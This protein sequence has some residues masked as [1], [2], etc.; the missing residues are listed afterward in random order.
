MNDLAIS[1]F[2]IFVVVLI[3]LGI[4]WFTN[5]KQKDKMRKIAE[6][7]AQKGWAY[8][9][10]REPLTW[11]FR[12]Q[13]S[14]WSIE[15]L[16]RSNSIESGP[17]SSN[18][19][20]STIFF[21]MCPGSA[22]I[23]GPRTSHIDLGLIGDTL[24]QQILKIALGPD[25]QNLTEIQAGSGPFRQKFMVWAI[26]PTDVVNC[27]IPAIEYSLIT[28]KGSPLLIKRSSQGLFIECREKSIDSIDEIA[29]L[30]NIGERVISVLR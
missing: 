28:W 30:I 24:T 3:C 19:A 2:L 13:S 9:N 14:K 23:I 27:V 12:L 7:A 25:A 6:F 11:G 17:G 1:L 10:I 18:I 29:R 26:D 4:L 16:S 8:V 22:F 15:S 20:A 5:R 21:A